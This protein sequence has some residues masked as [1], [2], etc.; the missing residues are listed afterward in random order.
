MIS[1]KEKY[2]LLRP[3]IKDGDLIL[4]HGVGFVAKI[5]QHCDKA[6]WNHIGVVTER[7]GALFIVDSTGKGVQADRLSY[8]IEKYR[9][10]IIL[11]PKV[12]RELIDMEMKRLLM[13]S[14]PETIRYDFNN[15]IKELFNRKFRPSFK[16]KPNEK[17]DICSDFVSRYAVNLDLV[18]SEFKSL[19][20]PFP[21]DYLRHYNKNVE[22]IG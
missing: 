13:R 21:E 14:D 16:I 11:K 3:S 6:Y 1:I 9:D 4:F 12:N 17:Q 7:H 18:Y 15:G 8:R 10:F 20:V 19:R 22:I 2:Q 5:I